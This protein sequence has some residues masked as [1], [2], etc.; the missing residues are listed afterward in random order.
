MGL[1]HIQILKHSVVL[2]CIP[3]T[4]I[5]VITHSVYSIMSL[6]STYC[7]PSIELVDHFT[8]NEGDKGI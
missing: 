2:K 6:L 8:P 4:I 1:E 7:M 3:M 5:I